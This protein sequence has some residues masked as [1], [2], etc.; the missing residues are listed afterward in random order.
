MLPF[1]TWL[2]SFQLHYFIKISY[3]L[4]SSLVCSCP[5][6][7]PHSFVLNPLTGIL[8]EFLKGKEVKKKKSL[9]LQVKPGI[10]HCFMTEL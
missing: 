5:P 8:V 7:D 4:P 10:L 9:L 3:L 2:P 1:T 6:R